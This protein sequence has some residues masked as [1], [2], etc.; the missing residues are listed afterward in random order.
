[1][2]NSFER[3]AFKGIVNKQDDDDVDEQTCR[4]K[5]SAE[6]KQNERDATR[7]QSCEVGEYAAAVAVMVEKRVGPV[8]GLRKAAAKHAVLF[9]R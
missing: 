6:I 3:A 2:H 7:Q 5:D 9:M 1:M 4:T 8:R